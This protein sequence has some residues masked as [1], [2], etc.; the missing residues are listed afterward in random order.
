MTKGNLKFKINNKNWEI[1]EISQEQ[2]REQLKQHN[3]RVEEFGKYYGLTYADTQTIYLDKD[4]CIDRK[5]TTLL[6]ELGHC[7]INTYI[8]HL[9]QNYSEEDVVDI[10]ANSH[11]IIREIVD[12]YFNQE[13]SNF[14]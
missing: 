7:Y 6:H 5:R 1:K 8:T 14:I 11:D 9:D 10:I 4:L 13:R 3:D 12:K 2:M